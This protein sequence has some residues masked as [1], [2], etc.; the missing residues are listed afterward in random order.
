MSTLCI[1]EVFTMKKKKKT[2]IN[3]EN[4]KRFQPHF[5]KFKNAKLTG[6][7]QYVYDECGRQ[8]K[9]LGIT[10]SPQTNGVLNVKLEKNPEPNNSKTAY[11]RTTPDKVDKGV[12]NDKLKGW[13]FTGKDKEKVRI[14]IDTHDKKKK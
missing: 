3:G 2:P 6:H 11:V 13:K 5:R 4:K 7:P 1:Y 8:Y 14:I 9:V 12:R 10:S